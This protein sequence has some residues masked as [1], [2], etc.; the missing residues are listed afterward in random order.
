MRMRAFFG[1][2]NEVGHHEYFLYQRCVVA[3]FGVAAQGTENLRGSHFHGVYAEA[4]VEILA[5]DFGEFGIESFLVAGARYAACAQTAEAVDGQLI[6]RDGSFC[7]LESL[8]AFAP[9]AHPQEHTGG[10]EQCGSQNP[11]Q[12]QRNIVV[13]FHLRLCRAGHR[14]QSHG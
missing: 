12:R 7:D 14:H 10:N 3:G 2:F 5:Q 4:A 1:E 6:W 11:E 8:D 9:E 13:P